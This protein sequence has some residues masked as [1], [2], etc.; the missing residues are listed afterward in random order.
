MSWTTPATVVAGQLMTAAFWNQQIRDNATELRQGGLA[1]TSQAAGDLPYASTATQ[2]ARLAGAATGAVLGSGGTGS[3]P[4]WSRVPAVDGITFP[5]TQVANAGA[6]VLD[7]YEES[8]WTPVIGGVSG[9]SGQTYTSQVGLYTKI[10][11]LVIATFD[12][13]LSVEGTITGNVQ[14]QGLPFTPGSRGTL[15]VSYAENLSGISTVFGI[16]SGSGPRFDLYSG[17]TSF[18]VVT[19]TNITN[20]TRLYGTC[21]F[22][23]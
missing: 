16:W 7:D 23:V 15:V 11:R 3:A 6:N 4:A 18:T 13:T 22:N 21:V 19:A 8:T 9:T 10:G 5:A 14:I 20:T 17:N 12:V 2:L 1:L